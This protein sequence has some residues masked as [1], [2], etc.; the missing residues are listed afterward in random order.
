MRKGQFLFRLRKR[1]GLRDL[2]WRAVEQELIKQSLA[3]Q[4]HVPT[5]YTG[6]FL[7]LLS[8]EYPD[9]FLQGNRQRVLEELGSVNRAMAF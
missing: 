5:G 1:S 3:L 2:L 6:D 4:K 9:L 7:T 8:K